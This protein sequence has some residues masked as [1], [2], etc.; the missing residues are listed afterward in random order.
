M[1]FFG[2]MSFYRGVKVFMLFLLQKYNYFS[3]PTNFFVLKKI[4]KDLKRVF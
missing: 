1:I 2:K 3:I 4:K